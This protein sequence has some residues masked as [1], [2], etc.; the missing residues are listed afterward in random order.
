MILFYQYN[1]SAGVAFIK[2]LYESPPYPFNPVCVWKL[3]STKWGELNDLANE[4]YRKKYSNYITI[5]KTK[6]EKDS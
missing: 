2:T 5:S 3:K 4:S 6:D 1:T